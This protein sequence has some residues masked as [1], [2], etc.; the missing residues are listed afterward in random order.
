MI[1]TAAG[2]GVSIER[3]RARQFVV[4]DLSDF[5]HILAMDADNLGAIR[6][7]DPA[8]AFEEAVRLFRSHDPEAPAGGVPDP[9]Y[10]G[11]DGFERVF[12]IV[13]RTAN[14]LLDDL[15]AR[16]GLAAPGE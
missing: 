12:D 2:H 3:Q 8:R 5:D 13:H 10:G 9:Y 15:V 16:H 11:A 4:H 7:M 14:R 6:A 1:A